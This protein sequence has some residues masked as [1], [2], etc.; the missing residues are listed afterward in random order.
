MTHN[1]GT[2]TSWF[3]FASHP[4]AAAD[5]MQELASIITPDGSF[6]EVETEAYTKRRALE[7]FLPNARELCTARAHGPRQ[8]WQEF[9]LYMADREGSSAGQ[10]SNAHCAL[11]PKTCALLQHPDLIGAPPA[12]G[13]RGV[14]GKASFIRLQAGQSIMAHCGPHR[15]V[16]SFSFSLYY[17]I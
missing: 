4:T 5:V 3:D 1:D 6:R 16:C 2:P 8:C 12:L 14:P 11:T 10:W 17:S 9:S 15:C 13:H 7:G